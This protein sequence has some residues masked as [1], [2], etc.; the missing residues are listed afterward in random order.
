MKFSTLTR[1]TVP[2]A[3]VV[4]LTIEITEQQH[5][6]GLLVYVIA[7]AAFL[8]S[9]GIELWGITAGENLKKAWANGAGKAS[10]AVQMIAYVAVAGWMLRTNNTLLVLPLVAALAY[11]ASAWADGYQDAEKAAADN[12]AWEREQLEKDR[13]L[14]RELKRQAQADKTAVK[15][16]QVEVK[17]V[18]KPAVTNGQ[19]SGQL[20]GDFRLLTTEQKDMIDALTSGE[21][22]EMAAISDRTARRWKEKVAANGYH[23]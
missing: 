11:V 9:V 22:A 10:T 2:S 14:E 21:L 4:F 1:I 5:A 7:A 8:S 12:T 15:L 23:K 19:M 16:A 3:M 18:T 6:A 13:A 20:P 17:A